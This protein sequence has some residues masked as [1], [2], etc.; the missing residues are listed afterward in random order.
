[1]FLNV[2]QLFLI[3]LTASSFYLLLAIRALL[4]EQAARER[5]RVSG[6]PSRWYEARI[7]SRLDDRRTY[8]EMPT[9]RV[10]R[11]LDGMLRDGR[12]PIMRRKVGELTYAI[13]EKGVP[14]G[15]AMASV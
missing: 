9:K 14:N 4:Q 10:G 6:G 12:V 13:F 5:V 1:M 15:L 2:T 8:H 11:V 3:I 7:G